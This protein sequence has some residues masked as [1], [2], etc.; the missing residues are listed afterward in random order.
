MTKTYACK[1]VIQESREATVFVNASD[2]H[3]A[4]NAADDFARKNLS[5]LHG[6]AVFSG[7]S[8]EAY[9]SRALE[10]QGGGIKVDVEA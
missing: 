10:I 7:R 3:S 8:I 1:V 2:I 4:T 9:A 6:R 5:A